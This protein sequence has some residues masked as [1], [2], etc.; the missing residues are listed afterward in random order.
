MI[1]IVHFITSNIII[2]I[3][4]TFEVYLC[5]VLGKLMLFMRAI[6]EKDDSEVHSLWFLV[7]ML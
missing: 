4:C 6:F 3:P 7:N 1:L 5:R 2:V